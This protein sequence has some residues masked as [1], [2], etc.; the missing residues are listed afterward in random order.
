VT[1]H[2]QSAGAFRQALE[3]RLNKQRDEEHEDIEHLRRQVAFDRFLARLFPS[4]TDPT[5]VLKGGYACELRL[6]KH[7][8][9]TK[10]L[11][12]T[13]PYMEADSQAARAELVR[14]MLQD[15]ADEDLG[16]YF[17]FTIAKV[18]E[19]LQ[20]RPFGGAR[21]PV[22]ASVDNRQFASLRLDIVFAGPDPSPCEWLDARD[23]LG[24]AGISPPRVAVLPVPQQ[25]A[26]KVHAYSYPYKEN[27]PNDRVKDLTDLVA[28]LE[29]KP[30]DPTLVSQAVRNTFNNR[31]TH[32]IPTNLP[33]PP[34]AW[35]DEY[36]VQAA[37]C[38][39]QAADIQ[40]AYRLLTAYWTR[41]ELP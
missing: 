1:E 23:W 33:E 3:Q 40:A 35:D 11:D 18:K 31:N 10:D 39:L 21:F 16:D 6:G 24:F 22:I 2:Y 9:S 38:Q 8:R 37:A 12:L 14:E 28:F 7:A 36:A 34:H 27:N 29:T 4:D 15:A 25:F 20:S 26:E 41:L 30:P 13:V 32:V 17:T 19:Y 5:W